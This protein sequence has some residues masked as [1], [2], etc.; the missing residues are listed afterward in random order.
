MIIKVHL[1]ISQVNYVNWTVI[2]LCYYGLTMN[3]VNMHGN[4]FINTILGV[5][6]EAPGYLLAM[7]TMDRF[8]RK[9]ILVI[10]QIVSGISCIAAGLVFSNLDSIVT[11]LPS[12]WDGEK[13]ADYLMLFLSCVGKLGSSAAF[14]L[15]YLYTAEMF[16]TEVRTK[17]LGTCSM[18]ARVGS[19]IS[20]YIASLGSSADTGYIPFL[21][22]GVS[23]LLGG[24]TAI[25]LPETVGTELP[26][27]IKDA[28][29]LVR[30][31]KSVSKED[32]LI[33][34]GE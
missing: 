15:I 33:S 34:P 22:F 23:T 32:G 2:N 10:C 7:L 16:P 8:G 11:S 4:T 13:F 31:V 17:A 5:I 30:K 6:I 26:V 27:T 1:D 14:S 29:I 20:P 28:E 12:D 18:V 21:I 19:F 24:S 3:S 9:P 25:I